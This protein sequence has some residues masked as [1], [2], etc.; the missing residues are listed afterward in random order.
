MH[1]FIPVKSSFMHAIRFGSGDRLLICFHGFGEDAGKFMALLPSMHTAFTV[2]AIDL[3]FHGNSAWPHDTPFMPADLAEMIRAVLQLEK[4]VR[5]SLMGYS[6]GGKIV[7]AAVPLFAEQVDAV[8]LA[9]PD[10]VILNAWYNVAVYPGWGRRLFKSFVKNPGFVFRLARLLR[11][12]RL[13][14]ERIFKF[15]QVQTNTEAKRKKIYDVWMAMKNLAVE[16]E[17]V[18]GILNSHHIKSYLFIG[19]YDRVITE[20]TGRKFAQGL[21]DC[22]YVV[23]DKGHNL[24]TE[25]FNNPLQAAL[26][27]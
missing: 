16:L 8:I 5:F 19:R 22:H 15:L 20:K 23:L 11:F 25:A 2:V 10:G 18:K 26:T 6:L 4:Q 21:Q 3:P 27:V 13:L 17:E 12:M 24:I 7:L 14:D 9:A 1:F